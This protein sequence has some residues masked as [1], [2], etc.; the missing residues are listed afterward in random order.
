MILS[1]IL[2]FSKV[3]VFDVHTAFLRFQKSPFSKVSAFKVRFQKSPFSQRS[4]VN[5]RQKRILLYP[6]SCE[7]GAM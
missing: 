4:N 5:A 7:Y 2:A 3:S 1:L 6:F